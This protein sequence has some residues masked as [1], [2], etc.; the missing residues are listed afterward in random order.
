MTSSIQ[1][2]SPS[3]ASASSRSPAI[4][5]TPSVSSRTP[6]PQPSTNGKAKQD[7]SS[8]TDVA[9]IRSKVLALLEKHDKAKVDRIDIIMEKFQGKE[10][11]LLEKMT[12]R[13]ESRLFS[14]TSSVASRNELALQRHQERMQRIHEKRAQ[15]NGVR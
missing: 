4:T 9:E 12:Q 13:Y 6:A 2:P 10:A 8:E 14:T 3:R 1:S 7:A 11:L 15:Q 5:G